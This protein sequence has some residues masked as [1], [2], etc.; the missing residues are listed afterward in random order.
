MSFS[1]P[2]DVL[3]V[4]FTPYTVRVAAWMFVRDQGEGTV[5]LAGASRGAGPHPMR[6]GQP[7]SLEGG[8][9]DHFINGELIF[10][11]AYVIGTN[12]YQGESAAGLLTGPKE[13]EFMLTDG[14]IIYD[15]KESP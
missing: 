1:Q 9:C 6:Y 12:V 11:P 7:S 3:P 8:W 2:G 10:R 15:P 5:M 14:A 4:A 13:R